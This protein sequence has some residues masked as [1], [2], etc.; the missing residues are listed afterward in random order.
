ML[1]CVG[2][3]DF[4]G[5]RDLSVPEGLAAYWHAFAFAIIERAFQCC[6]GDAEMILDE[7]VIARLVVDD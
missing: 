6:E 1:T 3:E 7:L 2:K 4:S 5:A